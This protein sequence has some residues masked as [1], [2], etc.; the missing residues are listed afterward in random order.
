[1]LELIV[2]AGWTLLLDVVAWGVF[3]AAAGLVAHR[4]SDATLDRDWWLLRARSFES[5]AYCYRRLLRV[6]RWKDHVPDAG[7]LLR[8]GISKHHLPGHDHAGLHAFVRE[9]RRAELA[10]W[11]AMATAPAF[12]F[13]NPPLAATLL[14][15]YGVIVNV[16]FI[17]IQRYNRSRTC[18]L[19]QRGATR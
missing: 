1:M 2:P 16:P 9:T 10:H 6:D 4:L 15:I 18:S 19:L 14:A 5:R 8:H 3:H 17:A 11:W 7:A 12:V 13:F